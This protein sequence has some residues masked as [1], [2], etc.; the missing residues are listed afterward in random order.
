MPDLGN[1]FDSVFKAPFENLVH[2]GEQWL[3]DD[4]KNLIGQAQADAEVAKQAVATAAASQATA[5]EAAV[6]PH[7][8]AAI[9]AIADKVPVIGGLIKG[10]AEAQA[11]SATDAIINGLIA[12]LTGKLST[13]AA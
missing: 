1:W 8:D 6:K 3:T 12:A 5:L 7:V 13:S 10:E 4:A 11:N 9:G 2:E